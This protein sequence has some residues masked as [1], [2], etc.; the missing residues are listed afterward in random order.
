MDNSKTLEVIIKAVDNA[1]AQLAQI[2]ENINQLKTSNDN[3]SQSVFNGVAAWDLLKKGLSE[4]SEFLTGAVEASAKASETMAIVKTNIDNA[5]Y[6]YDDLSPKLQAYSEQML[7]LGFDHEQTSASVSK[8]LLIT[9]DYNQAIALNGLAMDLARNKG[10][11]LEQA[12]TSLAMVMQG[13]GAK[14]LTQYGLSFKDGASSAEILMELQDKLKDSATNWAQSSGGQLDILNVKWQ[15]MQKKIGDDLMPDVQ[16][17]FAEFE[18]YLP[19][20]EALMKGTVTVV[21]A[22]ASAIGFVVKAAEELGSVLGSGLTT[23]EMNA[24]DVTQ[25]LADQTNNLVSAYNKAHPTAKITADAFS[26]L[27]ENTSATKEQMAL[28]K[29]ASHDLNEEMSKSKPASDSASSA[30][31]SISTHAGSTATDIKKLQESYQSMSDSATA[32]LIDLANTHATKMASIADSIRKVQQQMT[33][34][35]NSY[36]QAQTSDTA[37]V[38]DEI[39][40]SQQ[41]V[42]DLKEQLS[43]ETTASGKADLQKQL[44]AEQKN[45]DSSKDWQVANASAITE[46]ERRASL[47]QLQRDIEDYN[48]RRTLATQEYQQKLNDL[49]LDLQA[50]Q[51]EQSQELALYNAKQAEI[52]K[53]LTQGNIDFKKASDERTAIT[54]AEVDTQ[55]AYYQELQ[56]AISAVKTATS[57]ASVANTN[58]VKVAGGKASG[59]EVSAG[60][61]YLVGEQ[62]MEIFTPSS[63]GYIT[64]NSDIGKGGSIVVNINGGT[65]LSQDVANQIGN[66]I[67]RNLQRVARV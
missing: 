35:T 15:E 18:K 10:I 24:K 50:K 2:N 5:G 59:G 13:A 61:S 42:A 21:E 46:A 16:K 34:L 8:L 63:S 40:A 58:S 14:A 4:V 60:E 64:P 31:A 30:L 47:T 37:S 26:F 54:K 19:E 36:N 43:K 6:S 44:D 23:E 39:I 45:L 38:A 33:D 55:I 49:Q 41:K 56:K 17:F 67:V 48:S 1:S 52:V 12:T 11:S 53:I 22:L 32:D 66:M 51:N 29:T 25:Q 28:L 27:T 57:I 65:Y 7:N 20:L 3:M 62:G 9:G